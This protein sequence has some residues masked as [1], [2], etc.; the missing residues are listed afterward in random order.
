MKYI[1]EFLSF[2]NI[3]HICTREPG[4]IKISEDIREIILNK[5]NT[6]MDNKTE[7][8]LYAASR[9]QHLVEK[10]IPALNE[11]FNVICDRFIYSSLVYQGYA[12]G[13]GIDEVFDINNF[14]VE[15]KF[16]DVTIFIDIDIKTALNRL[17]KRKNMDRL[18]LEGETFHKKTLEGYKIV[19]EK[20]KFREI[21]VNGA[22]EER[23]V[24]KQIQEILIDELKI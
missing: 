9:R 20:Y 10:I 6:S 11:G 5:D 24:F 17:T 2:N 8:L 4:G 14:S 22:L 1:D 18:D 16:P 23:L 3:K 15:N 12:R 21:F 13:I 7:A 19:R